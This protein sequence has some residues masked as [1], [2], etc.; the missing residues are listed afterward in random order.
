MN[1]EPGH[2]IHYYFK[3][4]YKYAL[5]IE[6]DFDEETIHL[7]RVDVKKL[8]A[9]LRMMRL[10]AE[11][12]GS[13]KFSPRFK[14]MYLLTGKIRD[15]QLYLNL[16]KE[17]NETYEGRL[18]QTISSFKKE[19][20]TLTKQKNVFLS[21]DQ[22]A[23]IEEKI[24][25]HLPCKADEKLIKEFLLQKL[26][27][28]KDIILKAVNKDNELHS[29][30]KNIKDIIYVT[31][32]YR[33]FKLPFHF[34]FRNKPKLKKAEDLSATLGL[35]NDECTALLFLKAA[36]INKAATGEKEYLLSVRR[37]CLA[38]KRKLKK[39]ILNKLPGIKWGL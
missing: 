22:F 6:K 39:E 2:I 33:E 14:K 29:L 27:N 28:I 21:K 38:Q 26:T 35:F 13:L 34:L 10:E 1:N 7:F 16:L 17:S 23:A 32:I 36:D 11:K 30:R 3:R 15:G 20:G 12:P 19:L 4:L 31:S 37:Q 5:K 24:K 8:R 18:H 9:F 25:K